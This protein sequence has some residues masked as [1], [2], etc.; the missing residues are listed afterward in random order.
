[1]HLKLAMVVQHM[2]DKDEDLS[3]ISKKMDK[4]VWDNS[5]NLDIWLAVNYFIVLN[6]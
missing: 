4:E 5:K 1:M 6:G 2:V 3:D